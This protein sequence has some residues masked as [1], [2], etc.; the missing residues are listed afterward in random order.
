MHAL[1]LSYY[2]EEN[3]SIVTD[4]SLLEKGWVDGIS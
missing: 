4:P 2:I 1:M 3:L